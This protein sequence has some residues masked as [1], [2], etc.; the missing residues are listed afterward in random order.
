MKI[1]YL[2]KLPWLSP[3]LKNPNQLSNFCLN[4]RSLPKNH[5]KLVTLLNTIDT[6]FT[7]ISLTETWL[8]DHN[9][10]LYEI[11]GYSHISQLRENKNGGGVSIFIKNNL[12][13]KIR[14]DLNYNS[15][16]FQLLWIEIDKLDIQSDTNIIMGVI[17]RRPGSET[18][19]FIEKFTD[20]LTI[21]KNENKECLH[22]GDFNLDLLK[23]DTHNPTNEFILANFSLSFIP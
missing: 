22:S 16:D 4:I 17:Y 18:T 19:A 10:E 2:T 14:E 7:T 15:I 23:S 6:Q 21:I 9:F 1:G 20:I 13:F 3:G 12:N 8:Q 5:R 11:E